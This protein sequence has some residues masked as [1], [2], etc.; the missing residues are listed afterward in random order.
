VSDTVR[1]GS[2]VNFLF[3][4]GPVEFFTFSSAVHPKRV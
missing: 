3:E 4:G 1:S 2:Q